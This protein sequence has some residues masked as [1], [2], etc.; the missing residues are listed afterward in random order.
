MVKIYGVIGI[1][2]MLGACSEK[3]KSESDVY[4]LYSTNYPTEIGRSGVAT[5]D[6]GA[7]QGVNGEICKE[8]AAL[9]Q[10]DFEKRKIKNELAVNVSIRYWC[11]KGRHKK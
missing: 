9:Y 2:L 6:L 1:V 7:I 3:V 11:E 5:F 10:A 8:A 4:T